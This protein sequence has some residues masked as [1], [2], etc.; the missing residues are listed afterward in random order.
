M[1]E[2]GRMNDA[3]AL[4]QRRGNEYMEAELATQFKADMNKLTQAERA[5]SASAMSPEEKRAQLTE[6]RKLKILV[7]NTTREIA[8]K[9][10]RLSSPF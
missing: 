9:T 8:D 3:Q 2:E 10:I 7:A 1:M 4:L 6:I 5:I